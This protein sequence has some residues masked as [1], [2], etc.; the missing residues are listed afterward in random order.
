MIALRRFLAARLDDP[1]HD[2]AN[3]YGS[4]RSHRQVDAHCEGES[5]QPGDDRG[6]RQRRSATH[7]SPR[8]RSGEHSFDYR[9]HQRRLRCGKIGRAECECC[10]EQQYSAGDCPAGERRP[11][12]L[13]KLL[14]RRRSAD[15]ISGLEVLRYVAGLRRRDADDSADRENRCA[16]RRISPVEDHEDDGDTEKRHQRHRGSRIG[17]DADQADDARRDDDKRDPENRYTGCRDQSLHE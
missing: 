9:L 13:T 11:D 5:G 16:R 1:P 2:S 17:R 10:S 6:D 15:E 12:E 3:E 4:Q 8:Q 7:Q 14:P